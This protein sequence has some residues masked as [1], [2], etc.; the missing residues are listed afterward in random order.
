MP[1]PPSAE[2]RRRAIDMTRRPVAI[3]NRARVAGAKRKG[4]QPGFRLVHELTASDNDVAVAS[5]LL[6]PQPGCARAVGSL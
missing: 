2:V 6:T 5:Q 4:L 1:A 3:L